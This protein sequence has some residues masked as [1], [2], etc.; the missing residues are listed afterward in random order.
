MLSAEYNSLT[1]WDA[2]SAF[3]RPGVCRLFAIAS[4]VSSALLNCSSAS[5]S[6]PS[7]SR[8]WP[9]LSLALQIS[10]RVPICTASA[11]DDSRI[12]AA[13]SNRSLAAITIPC[14][15][16]ARAMC[17]RESLRDA[18]SSDSVANFH[19]SSRRFSAIANAPR[20]R[21]SGMCQRQR[22]QVSSSS[23]SQARCK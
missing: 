9:R 5:R 12:P 3:F 4:S 20:A 21:S 8:T 19:A 15:R 16:L 11:I 14:S 22:Y 17:L 7:L 23:R 10:G 2:S 13:S 6:L 1:G 18:I